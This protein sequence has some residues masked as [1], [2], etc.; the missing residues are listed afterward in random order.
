M[1]SFDYQAQL[2]RVVNA[3]SRKR[4]GERTKDRL[5]W[6]ATTVLNDSGYQDLTI[7]EVCKLAG[8]SPAAFYRYYPSK[9]EIVETVLTDFLNQTLQYLT[10]E[11]KF[12]SR[13]EAVVHSC[14]Y[15]IRL[16]DTNAGLMRC[17]L[18][19]REDVPEFSKIW[20]D[21]SNKWSL[22]R[23]QSIIASSDAEDIDENVALL[24]SHII[25]GMMDEFLRDLYIG[26]N[27][28][29]I[30]LVKE[31]GGGQDALAEYMALIWYR[32]FFG[33]NPDPHFIKHSQPL[34]KL[35]DAKPP[36]L[37]KD[38]VGGKKVT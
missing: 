36:V 3:N 29:L 38:L 11:Y 25:G 19:I 21:A 9:T 10:K 24:A 12:T 5:L 4:K 32:A 35:S 17:V 20:Q 16:F 18:Q 2:R 33:R 8:V 37:F 13:F 15:I 31:V 6:A 22:L 1:K 28:Q 23:A 27:P 34:I 7:A 30:H 14:S 26:K